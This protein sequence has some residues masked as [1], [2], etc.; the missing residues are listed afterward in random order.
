MKEEG[1]VA[2]GGGEELRRR[3]KGRVSQQESV[4]EYL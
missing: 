1:V 4:G 3:I 2:D